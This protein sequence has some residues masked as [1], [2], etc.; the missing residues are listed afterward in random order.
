MKKQQMEV[1]KN[2]LKQWHKAAKQHE[3]YAQFNLGLCHLY[4]LGVE[5]DEAEA[6][7]WFRKAA[8]QNYAEAQCNLSVCYHVGHGIKKDDKESVKWLRKAVEQNLANAQFNL[9]LRYNEGE[10]VVQDYVEAV[11]WFRKAAEQNQAYAQY[12]LGVCLAKGRG[13]TKD[14]AEAVKW[15]R[16]AAEQ[17]FV[18][19]QHNL[20]ISY[21][22]GKGVDKNTVEAVKWLRKAAEQNVAESQLSLGGCYFEGDGVAKDE[23]EAVRWLHK[24]AEQNHAQAQYKLGRCYDEGKCVEKNY[25]EA[26]KWFTLALNQDVTDAEQCLGS[27]KSLMT[28]EQ[29]AEAQRLVCEFK[30]TASS[31]IYALPLTAPPDQKS[32]IANNK[33]FKY[34]LKT[35]FRRQYVEGWNELL[36]KLKAQGGEMMVP[37]Y[38]PASHVQWMLEEGRTFDSTK[39]RLDKGDPN[40][41]HQNVVKLWAK[42]E[43]LQ[44]CKGYGLDGELWHQHSWLWNPSTGEMIET[45]AP[46]DKYFGSVLNDF[47]TLQFVTD[48]VPEANDVV[49]ELADNAFKTARQDLQK[50]IR[51]KK[52]ASLDYDQCVAADKEQVKAEPLSELQRMIMYPRLNGIDVQDEETQRH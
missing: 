48:L 2:T 52:L 6:V 25:V 26:Y 46:F 40:F 8:E 4:G 13:V 35:E 15:Y 3:A 51:G 38:E 1:D 34:F 49:T 10:G 24:A 19:A 50:H 5:K 14:E 18:L 36:I 32:S 33:K 16:K 39:L 31:G 28:P 47:Q 29:I 21:R 37:L 9:G 43:E 12:D 22:D 44:I 42:S 20:G 41:C 27:I 45:T 11:R 30:P 17:N 7:M 23:V